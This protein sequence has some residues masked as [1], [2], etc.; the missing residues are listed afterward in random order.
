MQRINVT[1]DI[2]IK[3]SSSKRMKELL[4]LAIW[5][6]MQ[7]SNSIMWGVTAYML[8]SRLKVGKVKADRILKDIKDCDLFSVEGNKVTVASFRDKTIKKNAKGKAYSGA[9][10]AKFEVRD[11]YKLRDIYKLINEKL[12]EY[13]ICAAEHK[14]CLM[15]APEEGEKVGVKGCA[16][17]L[18]Q[19]QE[20]LHM[21]SGSISRIKKELAARGTITSSVAEKHSFGVRNEEETKRILKRTGKKKADFI[22]GTLGFCVLACC[23]SVS[24]RMVTDS[25]RHLIYGKQS[26][27]VLQKDMTVAGLPDGFYC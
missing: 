12:F 4:A 5:I 18:K 6:K 8:R 15:K 21:G 10:V 16:I 13:Q 9:I 14:N 26:E 11:D 25:F 22:V 7:H 17:T 2:L 20:A 27:K 24:D 3:Y 1:I 23:Y 19:F